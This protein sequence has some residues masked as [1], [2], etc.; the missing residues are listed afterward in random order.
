MTALY[1]LLRLTRL[2]SSILVFFIIF[3]SFLARTNDLWASFRKGVPLLFTCMCTFIANDLDDLE[4]DRINHP[5]RPLPT[6]SITVTVAVILYFICL[7]LALFLTKH[8]IEQG[9]DFWYYGLIALSISY[10]YIVDGIPS[11]KAPYVAAIVSIPVL[12][13][14][15]SYPYETRLFI[16]ASAVFL[17]T[18]G[19]EICMDIKDR[20]GDVVSMMNKFR[21]KPLAIAAFFL[22]AVGLLLVAIQLRKP[23]DVFCL[24]AMISSLSLAGIYWFRFAKYRKAIIL[25][26]IQFVFGLYFLI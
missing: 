16:V 22:Q 9:F 13:I 10:G 4:K 26:K 8:F 7:G 15:F 1:S 12:M 20:D 17:I 18:L 21:A 5:D 6:G 23:S 3:I 11:V 25:M 24:L 19:R 14:A 2:D